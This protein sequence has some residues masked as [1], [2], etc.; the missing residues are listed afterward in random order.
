MTKKE[1]DPRDRVHL[2]CGAK[3]TTITPLFKDPGSH[4]D[5]KISLIPR[6]TTIIL[7]IATGDGGVV[8]TVI[9]A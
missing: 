6:G 9:E 1:E 2:E 4:L 5:A 8:K 7:A 3:G